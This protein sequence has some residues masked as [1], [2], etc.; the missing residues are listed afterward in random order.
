M[1]AAPARKVELGLTRAPTDVKG[2]LEWIDLAEEVGADLIGLGDG[3]DLWTELFV[4]LS[5][6]AART[7]RAKLGA[8]VSNPLTRHPSVTAAALA[9]LQIYTGGRIFHGIGTGLSA[10][11]N[12]GVQ[13]AHVG[14]LEQYV[15]AVRDLTA[16]RT[17]TW[18]GQPLKLSWEPS[19]VPVWVGARGPKMLAMAGRSADGV[20]VGGGVT[21]GDVVKRLLVPV[22]AG[23]TEAGRSLDELDV[24]WLTRVVVADSERQ[25]I[26]MMRDYLAGYAAHGF[27][28]PTNR[29][30]VPPDLLAKIEFMEQ[31]Y[32][33]SEH[34]A[35]QS[36][37]GQISH[38]AQLIEDQGIKEWLAN[39]FVITGPPDH[40]INKLQELIEAGATKLMIP[41]VLPGQ[42]ESTRLLANKVFP[43]FR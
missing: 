30:E 3:Q 17:A 27:L 16:G 4:T 14:E 9:T 38:N 28:N 1:A 7:R 21:S 22:E 42:M 34:L 5:L 29:S 39:R 19:P 26:D 37:P 2:I 23:A 31:H 13:G 20:I 12:I 33:W 11:R 24:W 10:L 40:C 15:S 35:G 36:A 32:R 41:Q 18:Q 6:A 8:V 43:A 25:G